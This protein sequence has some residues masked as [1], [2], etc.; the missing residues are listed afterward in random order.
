MRWLLAAAV[1][2][3]SFAAVA[4]STFVPL[5]DGNRID[6]LFAWRG[7]PALALV[8]AIVLSALIALVVFVRRTAQR[9][10][11]SAAAFAREG[12]WLAPLTGLG[13]V[14][15]GILPAVPGIG[16]HASPLA[17]FFYDLRWWWLALALGWTLLNVDVVIG[18]PVRRRFVAVRSWQRATQ[19]LSMD[20]AVFIGVVAWAVV[21]TPHLRFSGTLHG[22]EP[23]YI[24][25]CEVWY[26]GGGL[27]ISGKSLFS[28]QP[29]DSSPHLLRTAALLPR[30]IAEETGALVAD[31]GQFAAHPVTFRWSRVKGGNG[32]VEGKRGGI[33]EIYQPGP[34]AVL[35]PGYFI[36]R[37]LLGLHPGYQGEFPEELVM[38]NLTMLLVYGFCGVA[39]FRLLRNVI[40]SDSLAMLW[41]AVGVVI[42][43]AGAFAFQF[44][45]ELPALLIVLVVSNF[46]LASAT[47]S[48][49]VASLAAGA[50]SGALCW[51]HP[52]F[53]L[54]SLAI[55]GVAMVRTK[56]ARRRAF[57]AGYALVLLSV[58]GFEYRVTGSW[59]PTARWDAANTGGTLNL[60]AVPMNLVGYLFHRTWGLLPHAL[61]LIGVTPGLVLLVR[62]QPALV[63][64][65]LVFALCL[66]IPAAGHTL[67]AAA[68]TPGRL[69]VAVVPLFVWP[70]AVVVRRFW[71]SAAVRSCAIVLVIVSL[72]ASLTYNWTHEKRLGPL[73]AV[74]MSGWKPNLMFPDIYATPASMSA[75]SITVLL[76]WILIL[77]ALSILAWRRDVATQGAPGR[78]VLPGLLSRAGVVAALLAAAGVT[79]AAMGR[80][81][82]GD[83]LLDDREAHRLAARALVTLD[84][85]RVCFTSRDGPVDWTSLNP[86]RADSMT[87]ELAPA[88]RGVA[89]RINLPGEDAQFARFGRVH[90][91]FGDGHVTPWSGIVD[92][93]RYEH[94]Y[95][96]PGTYSVVTW[97]QLRD[98]RTRLDRRTI[99]I[100][101]ADSG[102]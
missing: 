87:V 13:F 18:S 25:Y 69:V 97:L 12:R 75:S 42:L 28:E 101:S 22:D 45:P 61:L 84:R 17:Y 50:A 37:Y 81:W 9:R 85:C 80:W 78:T 92:E 63:A 6:Y 93:G 43:P 60:L 52:R 62:R 55:T 32:F 14:I 30:T 83:Y 48:R 2:C 54:L 67:S 34:S 5:R 40:Q 51:M 57:V 98:G 56:S 95:Q 36:D 4:S 24:R 1:S 20:A 38:T 68:G 64:I 91:D 11:A 31:L 65:L 71:S 39:L 79:T 76:I 96:Q 70:V 74:D 26:Q 21:T 3:L 27:D 35:F 102:G 72:D 41:A 10:S 58:M 49:P 44:Y 88:R 59:L 94:L 19:L 53:L 66:G 8:S 16:A 86:N 100:G 23:K 47:H 82:H 90:V 7:G 46:L 33:Y 15:L 99:R 29:L 73:H 89:V 77:A